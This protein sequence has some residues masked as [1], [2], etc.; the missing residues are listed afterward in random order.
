M[1]KIE[2]IQSLG[3]KKGFLLFKHISEVISRDDYIVIKTPSNKKYISANF[4]LFKNPPTE[5][6]LKEWPSIFQK[7]F[8]KENMNH[9][10]LEWDNALRNDYVIEKFIKGGFELEHYETLTLGK[11]VQPK[12]L[13]NQIVVQ[14]IDYEYDWTKV[15]EDQ[16]LFKPDSLSTEYY[17]DFSEKL[18]DA[19]HMLITKKLCEWF[20]A[21]IGNKLV[22]SLGILWS[23]ELAGFQRM[24]VAPENRNQGVC[25][26]LIYTVTD[27]ILNNL[28]VDHIVIWSEKNSS[29]SKIYDSCGYRFQE[30]LLAFTKYPE[31][32]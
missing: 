28:K 6:S 2:D 30:D 11:L 22:G 26:T 1:F 5:S 13:N 19:Y 14:E 29:A 10:K 12:F 24:V 15:I 23:N 21:Y 27:W 16:M 20:G 31:K 18:M 32:E 7:E 3:I 8:A 25:S 4:I 9:I 17:K